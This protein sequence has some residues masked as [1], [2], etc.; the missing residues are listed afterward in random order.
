MAYIL[1]YGRKTADSFIY[2]YSVIMLC[3]NENDLNGPHQ[4]ETW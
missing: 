1:F 2:A 4:T 3:V